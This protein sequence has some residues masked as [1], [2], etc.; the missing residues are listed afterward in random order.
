MDAAPHP[1]FKRIL[2]KISGEALIGS[3]GYG[4]E[5]ATLERI[6]A[7]VAEVQSLGVEIGVVIGGEIFSAVWPLRLA[8]WIV[9][10]L[11]T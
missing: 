1:K 5:P 10:R 11:I 6:A 8:E 9:L 3:S 7:E 2:L 4:I